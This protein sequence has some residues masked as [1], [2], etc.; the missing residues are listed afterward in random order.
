M[1]WFGKEKIPPT[2]DAAI[3]IPAPSPSPALLG[4][5]LRTLTFN[6]MGLVTSATD[7]MGTVSRFDYDEFANR[8]SSIADAGTGRLNQTTTWAYNALGD[9]VSVT[10]PS[11]NVATRTY[12]AARRLLT[13]AAP[14]AATGQ[15]SVVSANTYDA[16]GR[17]LQVQQSAGGSVLRTTSSTYT[18]SGK[19]ATATDPAGNVTRF[20]Y[21]LLDRQITVTD[22]IGR[23][24]Q[25]TYDTL[26]RPWRTY[27]TAIQAGPLVQRTYTADGQLATLADANGN[28]TSFASTTTYPLGRG[29]RHFR[30]E[31]RAMVSAGSSAHA[32]SWSRHP[33]PS[34]GKKSTYRPVQISR[35][36]SL[37]RRKRD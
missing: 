36:T 24:T 11:G 19:V 22:A 26:G 4:A 31:T 17:L 12:D 23:V 5:S 34:S 16:D 18:P 30:L 29:Q 33:G 25:F 9:I 15:A 21:D 13:S 14:P 28:T 8:I 20:A 35:A 1:T 27:N 2:P 3:A 7:P 6:S 32:L 10:D 37:F